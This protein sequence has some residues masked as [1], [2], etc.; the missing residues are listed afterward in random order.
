MLNISFFKCPFFGFKGW[1]EYSVDHEKSYNNIL[2]SLQAHVI[3]WDLTGMSCHLFAWGRGLR[4]GEL[5]FAAFS[6]L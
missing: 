3:A 5:V 1:M 2:G 4:L 6:L